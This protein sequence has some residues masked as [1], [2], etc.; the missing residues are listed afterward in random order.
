[1]CR[2]IIKF[3]LIRSSLLNTRN[4]N[5]GRS[6]SI[7][8][9]NKIYFA[10]LILANLIPNLVHTLPQ[11]CNVFFAKKL[12]KIN[13]KHWFEVGIVLSW[14]QQHVIVNTNCSFIHPF[15]LLKKHLCSHTHG[16]GKLIKYSSFACDHC[17]N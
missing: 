8:Q 13:I 15:N 14:P 11:R 12:P 3:M 7:L 16:I 2:N 9:S 4:A 5:V 6:A 1:M 10:C 17:P